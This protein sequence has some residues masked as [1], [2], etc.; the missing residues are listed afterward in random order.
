MIRP[1]Y[2]P[3][4]QCL[5]VSESDPTHCDLHRRDHCR[6]LRGCHGMRCL[7]SAEPAECTHEVLSSTRGLSGQWCHSIAGA[8]GP[9]LRCM[10]ESGPPWEEA[11][12]VQYSRTERAFGYEIISC[13]GRDGRTRDYSVGFSRAERIGP[14]W[15]PSEWAGACAAGLHTVRTEVRR[16]YCGVNGAYENGGAERRKAEGRAHSALLA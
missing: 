5:R 1:C 10:T 14:P 13:S 9:W 12:S 7:A 16:D 6:R 8:G 4:L 3:S 2:R 15:R 11:L